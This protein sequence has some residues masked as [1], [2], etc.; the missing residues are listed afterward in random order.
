MADDTTEEEIAAYDKWQDDSIMVQWIMLASM[1]NEWQMQ[2]EQMDPQSVL[3]HLKELYGE[4]SRTARYELSKQLFRARMVKGTPIEA[5]VLKMINLIEDLG[6]LGFAMD[7]ELSLDLILQSLLELFSQFIVN[8]YMNKLD[9]SS[10][11]LFNLLKTTEAT[12][13]RIR[14]RS[15]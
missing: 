4:Q 1:R 13:R 11:E 5:Y 12:L 3:L 7:E 15:C 6:R 2:H 9:Y 10:P 14:A 8:S